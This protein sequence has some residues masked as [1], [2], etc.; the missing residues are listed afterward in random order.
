MFWQLRSHRS[1]ARIYRNRRNG[2]RPIVTLLEERW[3]LSTYVVND[4]G[5]AALDSAVG[6]AETSDG[7]I[8]LRSAIEQVN[9]DGGGTINFAEAMTINPASPLPDIGAP[10]EID[11]TTAPG[12]EA[13]T[14]VIMLNGNGVTS[15]GLTLAGSG[16]TIQGLAIGKFTIS[17]IDVG[18]NSNTILGTNL[19]TNQAASSAEPNGDGIDVNGSDNTI[20]GVT[21]SD[22]DVISGNDADGVYIVGAATGNV[23]EGDYIGI[24]GAGAAALPNKQCGIRNYGYANT[25]GGTTA[26]ARN[27]ISGNTDITAV[28][29]DGVYIA[30]TNNV[31][32]GN[33]IG[34][35]DTG[36][37][38]V[39]NALDGVRVDG[40]ANTI[41]GTAPGAGNV[42]SGNGGTGVELRGGVGV[43][44]NVVAGNYIGT[45][46]TGTVAIGNGYTGV[47][48]DSG[49]A[50]NTI[51]GTT[52]GARNVISGNGGAGIQM[53]PVGVTADNIVEGNY[54]GTDYTGTVALLNQYFGIQLGV[55]AANNT[56]G[57][58]TAGARN[59]ISGNQYIGI[60]IYADGGYGNVVE[61]NYI[62][63]DYTGT[64][65]VGN[66]SGT[67]APQG[68][69]VIDSGASDN[70]I[71]G[72]SSGDANT[73]AFNTGGVDIG[74]S[75]TDN[76]TGDAILGNSIYSNDGLGIDLGDNGVVQ[77]DSEGHTGPN[78]FQNFPVITAATSAGSYAVISG[79][80]TSTPNTA[81]TI[82]FFA[83]VAAGSSGN[84]EGQT[85]L[86]EIT[87]ATTNGSGNYVFNDVKFPAVAGQA[88]ITATATDPSGNTSE[89]SEAFSATTTTPIVVENTNDSGPNS[90]RAAITYADS[91][92]S[93]QTIMFAIP[94][95]G[96]QTIE[97]QSA[98]PPIAQQVLIDGTTEQGYNGSPIIQLEGT[99]APDSSGLQFAAGSADST[100]KGLEFTGWNNGIEIDTTGVLVV[101]NYIGYTTGVDEPNDNGVYITGSGN[102]VGGTTAASLNVISGNSSDGVAINGLGAVDNVVEGNDIGTDGTGEVASANDHDGILIT[103]GASDNRIG[104]TTAAAS[105]VIS[106]NTND[107]V[108]I[109]GAGTSGNVVEDDTIGTDATGMFAVPNGQIGV[110]VDQGAS[111]NT[112]GDTIGAPT[113]ISGNGA[114]GVAIEGPGTFG[115]VVQGD[116]IGTDSTGTNPLV[117]GSDQ[118]VISDGAPDNT[119]G[120]TTAAAS[121]EI[122]DFREQIGVHLSETGTTGN[123]VE[124]DDITG[125]YVYSPGNYGVLI[126]GGATANTIGGTT[127]AAGN[128]IADNFTG[129]QIADTGTT[130]NALEGNFIGPQGMGTLS[131]PNYVGVCISD[132][133]SRNTIGGTAGGAGNVI[134]DTAGDGITIGFTQGDES[135]DNAILGNSIFG[136]TG[137]G[138]DLGDDG[139]TPNHSSPTTG[140]I[141]YAP[142]GDQNFP[143]L[144]SATF[145]PDV[146]DANGT[147]IVSGSLA[148]DDNSTYIIQL[149]SNPAAD[150]SGYGQ[151]QT[152]IASFDV[153]TDASGAAVFSEDLMNIANLTGSTISA[154]ATDPN[155]NTSEFAQDVTVSSGAGASIT[156]PLGD[157]P[158]AIQAALQAAV[159]ELQSLP[160]GTALPAVLLD[161][162]SVA[163]LDSVVAAING[164]TS[165]SSPVITVIVDL[166]GDTDPADT[167]LDP[168][169]GIDVTIQNGTL[170]GGSPALIVTGGNVA[171]NH[172]TA[173]NLTSAPTIL[174]SGGSLT[175]RNST[176]DG[177]PVVGEAAFSITAGTL[178]LGTSSSPGANSINISSGDQFVQNA[179]S[180]PIPTVGDTFTVSGAIRAA[181]E[182]SFT[183]LSGPASSSAQGQSVTFT[184]PVV[185]D[186]PGDPAPTGYVYFVDLTTGNTLGM[187]KLTAG[188]AAF[189]TNT[190]PVGSNEIV[191]RYFGD[192]RYLLSISGTFNQTV[193]AAPA[194][195]NV[196]AD[197]S[198]KFGGFIF[199]R[200]TAQLAQ[201]LTITNTSGAAITWPIELVFENLKNAT[202]VNRTG[203]YSGTPYITILSSGSLGVGQSL[204]ISLLFADPTLQAI[205]YTAEF[206]AG[207]IPPQ[208]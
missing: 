180:T 205:T 138:I 168:P 183:S 148:A 59:V 39:P 111:D 207:P 88:V 176:I 174:V 74:N 137:I 24:N 165:Q 166:G 107:G 120:G 147:L 102:T 51:G 2:V 55:Y 173:T 77:N 154:T 140:I 145:V 52:V 203:T 206:L 105:N 17:G 65:A 150:P 69:V 33:F 156:V 121:D 134:A 158:A 126:D 128:A 133:A 157:T 13:G 64:V 4:S 34:T 163:Q 26:G 100:I 202:L 189:S 190:L 188:T 135:N 21:A 61:G 175:V 23:V 12:Y 130:S 48:L 101:G 195:T 118:V 199:N 103:D 161:V 44:G 82:Q 5:D 42:I 191:A 19:G 169:T 208:S 20:G 141:D 177:S 132:G 110:E 201:S 192:S 67:Y 3:L 171:L 83:S 96:V 119:I 146:S 57:G 87:N 92:T 114:N 66:G 49:A 76:T 63:T 125:L 58:T 85:Y 194:L 97:P 123:V 89:F 84:G 29:G 1:R 80:L 40:S 136:N 30:G 22:R 45:D 139:V 178:D 160:A 197:L 46:V 47:A 159:S 75:A 35:D 6:P 186:Y 28:F 172:V 99:D 179:T 164:L 27:V 54:I 78:L 62:G 95:N 122:F 144:A 50:D 56:I 8:T 14:P 98:L 109:S 143:V 170:E 94:G 18:G 108:E 25:I 149:F 162:T 129:V 11:G 142:N 53:T 60:D 198:I 32:V 93:P 167:S 10:A 116:D 31:V 71:G 106:G 7:T 187:V 81:F 151:G 68:G 127:A 37:V 185:P 72:T 15:Y 200:K 70:T 196:T 193:T 182:L 9:I 86:G 104:G 112:I 91:Q 152:L 73:I 36:T 38:A 153:T 181:T 41:G 204:T 16:I 113:V 131:A 79:T 124:G 155:G 184:A 43:T 90:L 117:N 115:N